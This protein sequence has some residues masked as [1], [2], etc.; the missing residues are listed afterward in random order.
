MIIDPHSSLWESDLILVVHDVS[1]P[2]SRDKLNF[3]RNFREYSAAWA[4]EIE[5]SGARRRDGGKMWR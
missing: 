4:L 1:N 5:Y 2:Y 3:R